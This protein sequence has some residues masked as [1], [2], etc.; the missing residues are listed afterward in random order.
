MA[1][2]R[3]EALQPTLTHREEDVLELVVQG[4]TNREIAERLAL[5]KRTVEDYVSRLLQKFEVKR[6]GQLIARWLDR[7]QR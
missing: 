4:L 5:S 3:D 6:R 2:F 7:S 1:A